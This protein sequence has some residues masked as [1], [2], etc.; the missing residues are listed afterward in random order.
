MHPS[1][2]AATA[3]IRDRLVEIIGSKIALGI[4]V[5]TAVHQALHQAGMS[6]A[7]LQRAYERR[8]DPLVDVALPGPTELL[9]AYNTRRV[10]LPPSLLLPPACPSIPA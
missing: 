10:D 9:D 6:D 3:A 8:Y 5:M 4:S 2:Q 1:E 7:A